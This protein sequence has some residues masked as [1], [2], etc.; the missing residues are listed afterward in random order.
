MG[1]V[2]EFRIHTQAN[3]AV[4]VVVWGWQAARRGELQIVLERRRD[5]SCRSFC[6]DEGVKCVMIF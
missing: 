6:P 1:T 3:P 2:G 4:R 5:E